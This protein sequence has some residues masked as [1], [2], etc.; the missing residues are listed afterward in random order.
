MTAADRSGCPATRHGVYWMWAKGCVCFDTKVAYSRYRQDRKAGARRVVDA[1]ASTRICQ[2]LAYHG[3]TAEQVADMSG[4]SI[5][6]VYDLQSGRKPTILAS[7][8]RML[9]EAA[10]R[11]RLD[12]Q[13]LG[14]AASRARQAARRAGWAPL[15]AWDDSTIDDPAAVP[16]LGVDV[17]D[18][19][20][21]VAVARALEGERVRLTKAEQATALR[22][23]L[24]QGRQ[25][26]AV[27]AVLHLNY[28]TARSLAGVEPTREQR[29][30]EI[31]AE[32]QRLTAA[33]HD[34]Y[35]IAALTGVHRRTVGRALR[36]IDERQSPQQVAS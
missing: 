22:V 12:Q 15:A 6:V 3:Y 9:R 17:R 23:G 24:D 13:R 20:D 35:T 10:D 33:G 1:T 28:T 31:D 19:V 16:D 30:A 5:R 27:A 26:S 21:E 14:Y 7:R 8:D 11:A 29:A 4:V 25:L 36:R 34:T 32:V 2:G 18:G